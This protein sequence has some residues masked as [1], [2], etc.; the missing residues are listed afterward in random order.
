MAVWAG[1]LESSLDGLHWIDGIAPEGEQEYSPYLLRMTEEQFNCPRKLIVMTD[2]RSNNQKWSI[3]EDGGLEGIRPRRY[4][5]LLDPNWGKWKSTSNVAGDMALAA[6]IAE[7]TGEE[8]LFPLPVDETGT[9]HVP[10]SL[11]FPTM[12]SRAILTS[13]ALSPST[14]RSDP[15]YTVHSSPFLPDP[16][17]TYEGAC[18][19]YELVPP[20]V[21]DL[22]CKKVD[23][24]PVDAAKVFAGMKPIYNNS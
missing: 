14:V 12:L 2:V 9:L 17:Q 7:D 13:S 6:K 11:V 5:F 10:A 16:E 23:A 15:Y 18:H 22:V 4:A 1:E 20:R 24:S 3:L 19:H 21:A 8:E